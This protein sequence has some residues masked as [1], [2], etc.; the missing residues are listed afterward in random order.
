[1]NVQ[2]KEFHMLQ[3]R[4]QLHAAPR[5]LATL[6]LNHKQLEALSTIVGHDIALTCFAADIACK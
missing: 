2:L 1:M 4:L 6:P 3:R 5:P